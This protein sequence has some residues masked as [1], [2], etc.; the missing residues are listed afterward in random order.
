MASIPS[1]Q[2]QPSPRYLHYAGQVGGKS[3]VWGGSLMIRCAMLSLQLV[4]ILSIKVAG[5]Q[6]YTVYTTMQ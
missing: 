3:Y 6:C 5:K 4:Q 2:Y 1:T